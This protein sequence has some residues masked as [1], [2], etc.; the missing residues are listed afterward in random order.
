TLPKPRLLLVRLVGGRS[1]MREGRVEVLHQGVW[2]TVCDDSW[3]LNDAKVVCG[4]LG[5]VAERAVES[6]H[7]GQG[8]GQ[9]WMDE[10]RCTGRE[11]DIFQCPFNGWGA[12]NCGHNEDAGYHC[13]CYIVLFTVS[14]PCKDHS[15]RLVGGSSSLE[16]RVEI[17]Y[18]GVWGT[19]CDD[20]WDLNDAKVVCGMLGYVAGQ[21]VGSAH[22]GQGSGQ[23]WMDDVRCTGSENDITQCPFNGWGSHDCSHGEEAGVICQYG[24]ASP[25]HAFMYVT[26]IDT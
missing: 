3:D 9:I 19:V 26:T 18:Q 13:S 2:G 21:A 23:I 10:V 11:R 22:F 16:G 6:A 15:V 25:H 8:S 24:M 14:F 5:Y 1:S 4:M 17:F 7:F 20:L 12:H